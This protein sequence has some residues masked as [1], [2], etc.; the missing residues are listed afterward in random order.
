MVY[1]C[2]L[3]YSIVL[4]WYSVGKCCFSLVIFGRLL[5]VIYGVFGCSLR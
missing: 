4:V 5:N 2:V 3:C 1:K